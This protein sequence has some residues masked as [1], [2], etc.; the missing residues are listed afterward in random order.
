MIRYDSYACYKGNT[1]F[2][3]PIATTIIIY[4]QDVYT[5]HGNGVAPYLPIIY[6]PKLILTK[7][8]NVVAK[9]ETKHN[10]QWLE[11]NETLIS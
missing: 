9:G 7:S 11:K 1:S 4:V 3:R 2:I 6:G 8:K 5:T 10:R